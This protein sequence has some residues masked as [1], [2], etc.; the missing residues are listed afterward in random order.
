MIQLFQRP[1][2]PDPTIGRTLVLVY[3]EGL[4]DEV[5]QYVRTIRV[6][7]VVN[8]YINANGR[9][10]QGKVCTC[11]ISDALRTSFLGSAPNDGFVATVGK[12]FVRDTS[13]ADAGSYYGVV[14][15]KNPGV[16]GDSKVTTNSV[17]THL[18]PS[19]ATEKPDLDV[20]PSA[21]RTLTLAEAPRLVQVGLSPHSMRVKIGQESRAF[22]Y[23]QILSPLPAP[24]SVEVSFLALGDWYT[25]LDDGAGSLVGQGTGT[26]NYLT[27]TVSVT[28]PALPDSSSSLIFAWGETR[29]YTDMS[30][31]STFRQPEFNF[32]LKNKGID[33]GTLVVTWLSGAVLKTATAAVDGTLSGDATGFVAHTIGQLNL[34][35]TAMLDAGGEFSIAYSW[36][37][38]ITET[39][40]GLAVSGGGVVTFS[41]ASVPVAGSVMVEWITTKSVSASS[42]SKLASG[43]STKSTSNLSQTNAT[44][45]LDSKITHH[46]AFPTG[47]VTYSGGSAPAGG[48]FVGDS[49]APPP[50]TWAPAYDSVTTTPHISTATVTRDASVGSSSKLTVT[51]SQ[52]SNTVISVYH[53]ITENG[54]GGFLNTLGTINYGGQTVTLKVVDPSTT[55][56]SYA[57]DTESGADFGNAQTQGS[58][59]PGAA[60]TTFSAHVPASG[61]S[62]GSSTGGSASSQG[63]TYNSTSVAEVFDNTALFV[64]YRTSAASSTPTTESYAPGVV[65]IDLAPY[66]Q[67]RIVPN[68]VRFTWMTHIYQ[69]LDGKLYRDPSELS[70]GTLAGVVDYVT[71][72]AHITDYVVSGAP[73]ALTVNSLWV[74]K[75]GWTTSKA[76]FRT[77]SAPVKPGGINIS[78][79]DIAG[80]QIIITGDNNGV[81]S[82]DHCTGQI[83]YQTG[84]VDL[85]FGD[86][87]LDSGLTAEDKAEWWYAKALTQITAAGK[88]WRPW[89][90][91]P[92]SLRFNA[93]SYFYL[94]LDANLL[95]LDPVRLPQ[96]GRVTIFRPGGF[97]VLGNTQAVTA[98]VSN[99][100]VIDCARV[101]LSRVR[102]IGFDGNVINTGYTAD[103]EA[104]TVTFT[105]VAGYSQPVTV[106][107]RIEDM[108]VVSDVQITG[109]VSFTR[110]LTHAYPADTSFL[111][112]A[113]V[114]GDLKARVSILFD[115]ATW[116]GTT[117]TDVVSGSAATGTFN[118]ALS[119]IVVTNKGAVSERWALVF[120]NSTSFN[121][122]G[123]HVGVIGTGNI[124]TTLTPL[125][126]A[127]GVAYFTVNTP[128][129][130][131]GWATGNIL[132]FNTVGAMTPVWVVRTVQQG[133]NTGTQHSFTLL[134]R[135]DVDRT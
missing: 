65:Q 118:D 52:V 8:S 3:R 12:T 70:P 9:E 85:I 91:D 38:T 17:Y 34:K 108:A 79:L 106:Q 130:G 113:L 5:I 92:N 115:Q 53:S 109:Q 27:G 134:S 54:V 110:Q 32:D 105:D 94:P 47:F 29:G 36:S 26:V 126:P 33:P 16:I 122:I 112:S 15:L 97:A 124:N 28:L 117:W 51:S 129:W 81:L 24:G 73:S 82:G 107:H 93:V 75:G 121:I 99:A 37:T 83:D 102:V 67:S 120:T 100:Q 101:R 69:D 2:T 76:F 84:V 10:Y 59:D 88:V 58:S 127:T 95:G 44:Q 49:P 135:G 131:S 87:V 43:S 132:R 125:N 19:A 71:G 89:P 103:L 96:D 86:L 63:G 78:V 80:D 31:L 45:I 23:V 116:N 111:S 77:P 7:S 40:T 1:T 46:A 123:E 42:G 20:V 98:T 18:V 128:G 61:A 41:T 133:P 56:Q 66:T 60:A 114:A 68:S 74:N 6:E 14:A 64:T 4:S 25:L 90:V 35:P 50:L 11:E 57:S 21:T 22:S 55:A 119:P 48:G 104:G 39:K 62:L 72:I 13:V 30:G